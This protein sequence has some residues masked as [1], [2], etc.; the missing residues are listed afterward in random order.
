MKVS[1]SRMAIESS[2]IALVAALA[3]AVLP[4]SAAAQEA[5]HQPGA[6][7][8]PEA[9]PQSQATQQPTQQPGKTQAKSDEGA[10]IVVTGR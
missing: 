6:P 1:T 3:M 5:A 9:T 8:Q 7:Q 10:E 2:R 4:T